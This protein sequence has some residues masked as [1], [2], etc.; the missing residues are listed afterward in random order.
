MCLSIVVFYHCFYFVFRGASNKYRNFHTNGNDIQPA[1]VLRNPRRWPLTPSARRSFS[2]LQFSAVHSSRT[3][4]L[5]PAGR[6]VH[7]APHSIAGAARSAPCTQRRHRSQVWPVV[8][9]SPAP[10]PG[11]LF[12]SALF[13][14]SKTDAHRAILKTQQPSSRA[15]A[16]RA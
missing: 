8:S 3:V 7:R 9:A 2:S 12:H 13:H 15:A 10:A 4:L 14:R 1:C 16:R 11:R 6:H 5:T